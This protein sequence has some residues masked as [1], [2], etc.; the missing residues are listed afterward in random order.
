MTAQTSELG[1]FIRGL[2]GEMDTGGAPVE[3]AATRH[4]IVNNLMHLADESGQF[5]VCAATLAATD[6]QLASPSTTVMTMIPGCAWRVPLRIR[7]GD[8]SSFRIVVYFR[9]RISAAGTATFR[10]A[11]RPLD[12][13]RL[14]VPVDPAVTTTTY[15]AEVSTT[16]TTGEDKTATLY[17]DTVGVRRLPVFGFPTEDGSAAPAIAYEYGCELQVWA[18]SSVGTS[19]PTVMSLT[20]REYA[21]DR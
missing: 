10:L 6:L 14:T 3:V 19:L 21:G 16:S 20:A 1:G 9:A 15:T 7:A 12:R 17:F 2:A 11:L 13:D 18:M 8:E 4:G 5:L